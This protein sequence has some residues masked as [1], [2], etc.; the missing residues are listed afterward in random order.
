MIAFDAA[1]ARLPLVAILR[2][3]RPDEAAD[4]GEALVSCGFTLIEVPLNSPDP[5]SSIRILVD[6]FG[7]RAVIGAGTVLTREQVGEVEAVGG[8]LIVSPNTD[9][10]VI[11]ETS[12]RGLCSLPGFFTASEAFVALA[13]GATGLK[14]FPAEGASPSYLKALKAVLPK[15]APVLAVGGVT[16]RSMGDWSAAG[17]NGFGIGSAVFKPG[18]DAAAVKVAA[19]AF[20]EAWNTLAAKGSS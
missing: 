3:L 10:A 2:G 7:D 15:S 6:R 19:A 17:A 4:V 5:L 18:M 16:P 1:F 12:T 11:A 20:V 8:R 13:A 9:P 14:L